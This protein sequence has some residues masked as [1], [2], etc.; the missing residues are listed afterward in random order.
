[1]IE[2]PIYR[3]LS[4]NKTYYKIDS[5]K[6]FIEVKI[7]GKYYFSNSIEASQF[8]EIILIKDMINLEMG[9][10]ISISKKEFED[11]FENVKSEFE[12][13]KW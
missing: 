8:P 12:L 10:F 6:S 1:M 13:R 11:F 2:F 5:E 9:G 3:K 4:D 7:M